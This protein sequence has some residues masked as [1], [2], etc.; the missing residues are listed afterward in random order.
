[1]IVFSNVTDKVTPEALIDSVQMA[2]ELVTIAEPIDVTI[3]GFPGLQ[4]DSTAKP[5]PSYEGSDQADIPP[6]VQF[7]PVFMQYLSP[8]FAWTTSSSEA[9][10]RTIVLTVEDQTLLLY[11]ESP[12]DE[13]DGFAG[14]AKRV[15]QSMELT[16]K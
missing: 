8:G 10:I 5:N 14:D 6:G 1:M 9:R 13:F 4:L 2:P 11:L 15:L 7:L 3:A 16:G 12:Q